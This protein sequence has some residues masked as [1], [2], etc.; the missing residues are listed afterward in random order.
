MSE[1]TTIALSTGTSSTFTLFKQPFYQ[2]E[3]KLKIC[4]FFGQEPSSLE[5]FIFC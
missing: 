3:Q 5:M 1:G 4:K 2:V